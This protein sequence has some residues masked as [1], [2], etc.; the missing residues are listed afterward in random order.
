MGLPRFRNRVEHVCEALDR[1]QLAFKGCET[2]R[3][4]T[5]GA[6]PMKFIVGMRTQKIDKQNL[7]YPVAK[8]SGPKKV[9]VQNR[10]KFHG[11]VGLK[12]HVTSWRFCGNTA[13]L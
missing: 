5:P 2:R 7:L 6:R 12:T 9:C 4:M 8:F 3:N 13:R 11:P 1:Q 10:L